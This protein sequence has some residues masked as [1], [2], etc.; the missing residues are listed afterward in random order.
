MNTTTVRASW[1][2]VPIELQTLWTLS[3]G[4]RTARLMMF[5]HQ[6]GW[7][8]K[9]DSGDMLLTQVC[10]SDQEIEDVS[11]AWREAMIEKGWRCA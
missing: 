1:N 9:I 5:T 8:L 7:E 2:G 11:A 10:R 6:L 3:K 4:S